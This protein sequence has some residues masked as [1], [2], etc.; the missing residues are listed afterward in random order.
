MAVQIKRAYADAEPGDGFRVL[1]DRLWPRGVSR[2]RA[3][4]D[5]WLKDAAPSPALRTWWGHDPARLD[6]FAARYRAELESAPAAVAAVAELRRLATAN[7]T[8]TLV[9]GARDP[10]VNHAAVLRDYL[11][12]ASA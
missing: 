11:V 4:L 6:E 8:L 12:G 9:Y 10:L 3:A 1:V 7:P 5:L 2:E